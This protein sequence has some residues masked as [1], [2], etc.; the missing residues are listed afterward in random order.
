MGALRGCSVGLALL[1]MVCTM[2]RIARAEVFELQHVLT[3]RGMHV[4]KLQESQS[5]ENRVSR[6]TTTVPRA[7]E[8]LPPPWPLLRN[9]TS[10]QRC[11][12]ALCFQEGPE[13]LQVWRLQGRYDVAAGVVDHHRAVKGV[14]ELRQRCR[15]RGG[16]RGVRGSQQ[17]ARRPPPAISSACSPTAT[18]P[19][20]RNNLSGNGNAAA[21]D[22]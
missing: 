19:P 13:A 12:L 3:R 14:Y 5:E 6:N 7:C 17:M 9:E 15:A 20:S 22:A 18:V 16:N 10:L 11:R 8:S 2:F 4:G 1:L 21:A